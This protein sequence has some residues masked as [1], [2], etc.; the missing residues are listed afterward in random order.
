MKNSAQK[1]QIKGKKMRSHASVDPH[2]GPEKK[3][4]CARCAWGAGCAPS[5]D[6]ARPRSDAPPRA[7][8]LAD[9][10]PRARL[11]L[12]RVGSPPRHVARLADPENWGELNGLSHSV[13]SVEFST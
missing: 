8:R 9:A 10:M 4:Q 12:V 13:S 7:T 5:C 11:R 3:L 1:I 6:A 2:L